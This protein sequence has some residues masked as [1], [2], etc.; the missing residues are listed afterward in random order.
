MRELNGNP[1]NPVTV[2]RKLKPKYG[3]A[4]ARG[5]A[6]D[7]GLSYNVANLGYVHTNCT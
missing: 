5:K 4:D 7:Y 3:Y 1:E 6:S 2:V